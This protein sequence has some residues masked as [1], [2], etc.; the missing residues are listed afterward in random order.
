MIIENKKPG[1]DVCLRKREIG[2]RAKPGQ[3]YTLVGDLGV[4]KTVFTQ[5]VASGLGIEE[6][7]RQ[8][9]LYHYSGICKRASSFL[10]F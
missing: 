4:G 5:G 2:K 10:S 6:P 8:P 9:D 7:I 1:G 3:I